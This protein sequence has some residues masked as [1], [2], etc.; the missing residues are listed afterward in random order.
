VSVTLSECAELGLILPHRTHG[1]REMIERVA[2]SRGVR[3]NVVLEMDA[4]TH[5]K[6]LVVRGA[7]Y[8]MLAPAAVTDEVEQRKLVLVPIRDAPMRRTVY[9][10]RNPLRMVTRAA[11]EI[12]RL[13]LD[14]TLSL[15][16]K[17][18]WRGEVIVPDKRSP[19]RRRQANV[20]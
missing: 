13:T 18:V 12:E 2:E 3:L 19:I 10:V 1:L 6:T 8:T 7:G 17:G 11:L 16:R 4:L 14:L 9:F 15:V 5:L 20:V